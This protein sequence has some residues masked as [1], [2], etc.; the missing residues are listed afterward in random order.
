MSHLKPDKL[1][2]E[3]ADSDATRKF[4]HWLFCFTNYVATLDENVNKLHTLINF[5]SHTAYT[6]IETEATYENAIKTLKSHYEKPINSIYARHI[7]STRKHL[8]EESLDDFLRNLKILARDCSF[9]QVTA[10]VY[11][12]EMIRDSFIAGLRSN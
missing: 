7:L 11:Q 2:I 9:K 12:D 3:P 8:A 4:K 10:E 5:I 1:E 6:Y